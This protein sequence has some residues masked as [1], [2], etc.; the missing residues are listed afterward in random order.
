MIFRCFL[1]SNVI[2]KIVIFIYFFLKTIYLGITKNYLGY[3]K[4]KLG[5]TKYLV[6]IFEKEHFQIE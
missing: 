2:L 5:K 4:F 1:S 3:T 6:F